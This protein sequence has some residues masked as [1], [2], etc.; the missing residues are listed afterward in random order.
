MIEHGYVEALRDRLPGADPAAIAGRLRE[1][2]LPA[3][4]PAP[5]R[6]LAQLDLAE[7]LSPDDR[8]AARA[9]LRWQLQDDGPEHVRLRMTGRMLRF[10]AYCAAALRAALSGEPQRVG[11][12]PGLDDDAARLVLARRLLREAVVVPAN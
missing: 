4:R 7:R 10:P 3:G 11:G 1:R 9:G 12:L 2:D 6:P 8:I 5:I